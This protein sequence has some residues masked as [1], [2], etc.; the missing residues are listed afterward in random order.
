VCSLYSSGRNFMESLPGHPN[1]EDNE[2]RTYPLYGGAIVAAVPPSFV[3][4]S[5]FRT[6]PDY[7]EVL[8]DT[9]EG[10]DASFIVELLDREEEATD[11]DAAVF[12]FN[13]MAEDNGAPVSAGRSVLGASS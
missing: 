10:R 12:Y 8:A 11:A 4:V 13:Q 2:P 6:V 1:Q 5:A 9:R 7:Q 3:D